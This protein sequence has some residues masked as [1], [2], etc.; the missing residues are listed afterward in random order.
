M[1]DTYPSP[2]KRRKIK[3][4]F[5]MKNTKVTKV[6]KP[7]KEV[8]SEL[9]PYSL[10]AKA[11]IDQVLAPSWP[12]NLIP[13]ELFTL[14][15]SYLPRSNIQN[16]RLVNKEFDLK[17]SEALFRIVVVPFR[18]EIYGITPETTSSNEVLQGQGSVMIQD[19][20][21]RVF[22]GYL[23]SSIMVQVL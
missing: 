4:A 10:V 23:E 17:V 3:G 6:T 22:Q 5:A 16:M 21:M 12:L 9:S 13:V 2:T 8:T 11:M 1:S 7:V 18:P 15:A 19:K 14:I 20:G